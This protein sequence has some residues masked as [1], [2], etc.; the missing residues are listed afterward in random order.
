MVDGQPV[1][2]ALVLILL[3]KKATPAKKKSAT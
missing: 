3:E 1:S 2:Y